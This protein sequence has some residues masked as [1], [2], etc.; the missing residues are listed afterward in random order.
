MDVTE[1][2]VKEFITKNGKNPFKN[3]VDNLKNIHIQ[4]KID[5][6]IARLRL[7]N[8]GDTKP[9]GQGVHELRIHFGPGYRIYYGIEDEKIILLLCGGEKKSQKKDIQKAITYWKEHKGEK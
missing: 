9:V 6:R 1:K 7:G 4:A 8:F 3:W 5:I 2:I